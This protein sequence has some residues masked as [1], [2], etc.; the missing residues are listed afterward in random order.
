EEGGKGV[1][2]LH[3]EGPFINAEKKGAHLQQYI[4]AP[5]QADI[6]RLL[7]QGQGIIKMMT[8]APECC[9]PQLVKQLQDAGI[10]VSAGHSNA[11]YGQAYTAF[12]S[13]IPTTTHLFNAMSALQS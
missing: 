10:L 4:T 11:T 13:G 12:E 9:E 6:D 7:E 1:L 2:G 5:A 3:L 8:L